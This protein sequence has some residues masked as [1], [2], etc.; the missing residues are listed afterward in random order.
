MGDSLGNKHASSESIDQW[1]SIHAG[2]C[3]ACGCG[4]IVS[5]SRRKHCKSVGSPKYI[6]GHNFRR[7]GLSPE[8]IQWISS[9]QGNHI[10]ACGCNRPI[11]ITHMM[12]RP[13][14]GIPKYILGHS[15]RKHPFVLHR[16][17]S[18]TVAYFQWREKVIALKGRNCETC[19]K[20]TQDG[21]GKHAMHV[22]HVIPERE[23]FKRIDEGIMPSD[24]LGD[25]SIG[26]V[27]CGH[28]H[29]RLHARLRRQGPNS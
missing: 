5:M 16:P 4:A 13:S 19:G 9:H 8:T 20:N 18:W 25:P 12:K 27:L 21:R 6:H 22:H 17:N 23:L 26:K 1:L 15:R 11:H 28:C 7:E 14:I 10:C 2:Q 29:A 24:V 3:C